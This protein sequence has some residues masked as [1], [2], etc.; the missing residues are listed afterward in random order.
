MHNNIIVTMPSSGLRHLGREGLKGQWKTAIAGCVLYLLVIVLPVLLLGTLSPED[1]NSKEALFYT[2]LMTGPFTLG[3]MI[4]VLGIFRG[5]ENV[6]PAWIF[7]GWERTIKS[8]ALFIILTIVISVGFIILLIPG[9]ILSIRYSQVYY[10]FADHTDWSIMQIMKESARLMKGNYA[11][12]FFLQLSFLGWVLIASVFGGMLVSLLTRMF[13]PQYDADFVGAGFAA[14]N[15]VPSFGGEAIIYCLIAFLGY[16]GYFALTPYMSSTNAVLYD[17]MNGNL[18]PRFVVG[19]TGVVD[20]KSGELYRTDEY[21]DAVPVGSAEYYDML[22]EEQ[23][24]QQTEMKRDFEEQE[25]LH[26]DT[27]GAQEQ[28]ENKDTVI[29]IRD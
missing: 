4:V 23:E 16:A 13:L 7:Y 8:I 20:G 3:Y 5:V 1:G 25:K 14:I 22:E 29:N 24:N 19:D 2:L 9:I 28:K 21:F 27:E 11:K 17:L 10:I 15:N 26:K 6:S 12:Y 18:R